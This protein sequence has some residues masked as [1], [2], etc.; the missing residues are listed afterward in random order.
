MTP[1]PTQSA[2]WRAALTCCAAL[3]MLLMTTTASAQECETDADC[4]AGEVC[5][6]VAIGGCA[7]PPC[8]EGQEC[9]PC[10]C[11]E[12]EY[13]E[14]VTPPITCMGD[15]DCPEGLSCLQSDS[16]VPCTIDSDG[17]ESCPEEDPEP[18]PGYCEFIPDMCTDDSGCAEGFTCES[19]GGDEATCVGM[20]DENGNCEEWCDEPE[21]SDGGGYCLPQQIECAADSDCPTEWSCHTFT[22]ESCSGGGST[23][24]TGCACPDCAPGED[25]PPCECDDVPDEPQDPQDPMCEE[26]T[27]NYCLPPGWDAWVDSYAGG[28]ATAGGGESEQAND[29]RSTG[30]IFGGTPGN[31]N[32]ADDGSTDDGNASGDEEAG[33]GG[34]SVSG[35]SQP[36]GHTGLL[37][38]LLGLTALVWRRRA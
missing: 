37:T 36:A 20:C 13:S 18:G 16:S 32:S 23:G 3:F 19:Y 10:E 17:N 21:P 34:C 4:S 31:D 24:G 8:M 25:C 6:V 38:I 29:G 28:G 30:D 5:E 12:T 2:P 22:S 11:D 1:T 33:G 7:C 14:C 27:E 15:S 35:T 9:P 26:Y